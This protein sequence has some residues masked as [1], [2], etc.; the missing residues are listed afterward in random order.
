M[1]EPLPTGVT[2]S[3]DERGQPTVEVSWRSRGLATIVG[4]AA[5]GMILV[6]WSLGVVG[7]LATETAPVRVPI[8]LVGLV[9]VGVFAL[10]GVALYVALAGAVNRAVLVVGAGRFER[11]HAPLPWMGRVTLARAPGDTLTVRRVGTRRGRTYQVVHVTEAGV[12][13]P[14]FRW[15]PRADVAE[16]IAALVRELLA[17]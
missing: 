11:F 8:G 16:R 13:T 12:T 4:P 5:I 15:I 6:G 3:T 7:L 2:R 10:G 1:S 17:R 14:L 9:L